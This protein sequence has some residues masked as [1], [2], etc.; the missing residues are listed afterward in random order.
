MN[1]DAA[2]A[3]ASGQ[4][5]SNSVTQLFKY[6]S[7]AGFNTLRIFGYGLTDFGSNFLL[8]TSPGNHK[9]AESQSLCMGLTNKAILAVRLYLRHIWM[10]FD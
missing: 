3:V 5:T 1:K 7:D 6:A 10:F 8:Q 4:L 9:V 2:D